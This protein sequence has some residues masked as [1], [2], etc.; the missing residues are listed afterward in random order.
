MKRIIID[1]AKEQLQVRGNF[2]LELDGL[3]GES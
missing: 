2:P 3:S 1:H